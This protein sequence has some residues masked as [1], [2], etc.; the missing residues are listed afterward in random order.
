MSKKAVKKTDKKR[1]AKPT[2]L[3]I[4]DGFGL[5]DP[6]NKGNAITPENAPNIF[7]Y[8][9]KYPTTE[10]IAHGTDVGLFPGQSGN[11]EAGHFNIGAGRVVKQDLLRISDAI[12]DGTFFKNTAL[13]Q[14][15]FHADKYK[16]TVH[17]VG[18]LTDDNSPHAK[19]EHLYALL[20]YLRIHHKHGVALHLFTD[21]RDAPPHAA[22]G[23]LRALRKQMKNGEKIA[24]V[25]GRLYGM[26][27]NKN[28]ARTKEAYEAI[29]MG[30]AKHTAGSAE[31]AVAQAYNRGETDEYIAPTII[32]EKG[33]PVAEVT[34]NDVV[35][36]FNARSD[37]ARQ[38]TKAFVQPDF[39]KMNPGAFKRDKHPK[40]IRFVAMTD[41]GPDLPNILTAF[42]SPDIENCLAKVIDGSRKQ[43]YI[44][45]TEKY[46]HVTF[47]LNGGYP[48]PING[49]T[50]Y[51][52][53]SQNVY[54]FADH[55]EMECKAITNAVIASVENKMYDFV[56]VN[57]PNADM[58]GH[59]GNFAAAKKAI[60]AVDRELKRLADFVLERGG[61]IVVTADHGNAEKMFNDKTGEVVTEH[62]INP[63][64]LIIIGNKLP[65]KRLKKGRLADVAPTLLKLMGIDKPREMTGKALF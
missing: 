18:L 53:K 54:S 62:T 5:A 60:Q 65:M 8:M 15:L 9:K 61:E 29:V 28:W 26:D 27:R 6:K 59:T 25:M 23:F 44:S 56:C 42:P 17:V 41:F 14:A 16:T 31:D 20:E 43:M 45:E 11:S 7:G 63:V 40:N 3:V 48:Q 35:Y 47:F 30:K 24:T 33:K 36:F 19:A 49:E 4:L 64:P 2:L 46:A 57:Y 34:D 52:V 10:L 58:V 50:R 1:G 22:V 55:P 38:L 37:R 39:V 21:G 51:L 13:D 12:K 32:L